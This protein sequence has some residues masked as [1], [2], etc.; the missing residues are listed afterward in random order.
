MT[1]TGSGPLSPDDLAAWYAVPPDRADGTWV[2]ASFITTLDG[3]AT[4]PDDVSGS[5][6]A[7][8]EGDH[9]VFEH[10]RDWA[11]VVVVG[12]GTVRKERYGALQGTPLAVVSTRP[13]PP[14]SVLEL[15]AGGG[16]VVLI[17]GHGDRVSAAQVLA[18]LHQRGWH[19]I[20]V[21]G[22]PTLFGTWLQEC[23]VDELCVTV[24]P[25]LAGGDGPFLVPTTVTFGRLV[26][27]PTHLLTWAGDVLVRTRL[28]QGTA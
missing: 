22:G 7:G 1:R 23:L 4:G 24:R 3:R 11:D 25:V 21:E 27:E 12:A 17:S 19:R 10:L 15:Q 18:A 14:R 2:R 28:R 20:V 5:L 8:S 6:N 26:G 9:A 13:E 16:E